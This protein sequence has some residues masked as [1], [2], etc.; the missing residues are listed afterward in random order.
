MSEGVGVG[1]KVAVA[2]GVTVKVGMAVSVK[3]G[4]RKGVAVGVRV[5]ATVGVTSG[6]VK[7]Q[8]ASSRLKTS[9][10]KIRVRPLILSDYRPS[11]TDVRYA[12]LMLGL[13]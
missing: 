1:V 7:L 4:V 8:A 10:R 3:V 13:R 2:E 9:T 11:L 12:E 6:T 5:G